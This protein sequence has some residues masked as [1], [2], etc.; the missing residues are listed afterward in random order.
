M[1]AKS[2]TKLKAEYPQGRR[3]ADISHDLEKL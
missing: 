3:E 2:E 1:E